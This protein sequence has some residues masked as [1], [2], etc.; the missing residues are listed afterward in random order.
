MITNDFF[1]HRATDLDQNVFVFSAKTWGYVFTG[2]G[3]SVCL[4]VTRITEKIVDE[5]VP[6]FMGRFSGRKG[7]T[8][9]VFRYD[10]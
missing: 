3:L 4:S 9:F 5:F 10:R 1:K 6:N 2:V 8:K 7:K